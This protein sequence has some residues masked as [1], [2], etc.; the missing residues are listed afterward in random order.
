MQKEY[1]IRW[2]RN[3]YGYIVIKADSEDQARE[4]FE[5]GEYEDKD[6]VVKNGGIEIEDVEEITNK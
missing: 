2:N 3:D 4:K 5:S 6:L 1:Y